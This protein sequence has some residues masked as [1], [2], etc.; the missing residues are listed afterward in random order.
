FNSGYL[1]IFVIKS[2]E[3]MLKTVPLEQ[4]KWAIAR[5][6]KTR[7]DLVPGLAFGN[8]L[9]GGENQPMLYSQFIN[10]FIDRD[11]VGT[12]IVD[13]TAT[14]A[15]EIDFR[16][17]VFGEAFERVQEQKELVDDFAIEDNTT[18]EGYYRPRKYRLRFSPDISYSGAGIST[19]YGVNGLYEL[20]LSD[21]LGD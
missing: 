19:G 13:T 7:Y 8:E 11:R 4:N 6:G 17:Y 15:R 1:D 18:E 3:T 10:R 12:P 16:N 20:E 14:V 9:F 2:P 5:S 21:L